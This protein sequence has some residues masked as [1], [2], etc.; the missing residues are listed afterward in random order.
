MRKR[1]EDEKEIK[2]GV[3]EKKKWME[4]DWTEV[5]NV[6]KEKVKRIRRKKKEMQESRK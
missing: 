4:E 5:E 1:E 3:K 2:K 6:G